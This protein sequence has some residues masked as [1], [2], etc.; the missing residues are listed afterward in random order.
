MELT[1][2]R[3]RKYGVEVV[4]VTQPTGDDPSQELMRQIIGIFDEYTSRENGKNVTRA[5]RESAKQGFWNGARAPLGYRVVEAERRGSK[6][7][8]KLAIDPVEVETVRLIYRLYTDGDGTSGPLGVKDTCSWLNSHG[9]R[10]RLGAAFGVGPVHKIL[11]NAG[12]ATGQWPYGIRNARTGTLNDPASIILIPVPPIVPLETFERVK[13]R[14]AVNNPKVTPP[15]VVN[16]PTLLAGLATCAACGSGMTRTGTRRRH[17][18]YTYYSCAGYQQKGQSVC[19]GLHIPM[20]KLDYAI[21]PNVKTQLLAPERLNVIL[22][23]LLTKRSEANQDIIERRKRL[24]TDLSEKKARLSRLHNAIEDGIVDL[25]TDLKERIQLLKNERDIIEATLERI[26][27]QSDKTSTLTRERIQAFADLMCDKLDNGDVQARKA[28]LRS[29]ITRIE[30][31]KEKV[32]IIG[33]KARLADIIA[34]KQAHAKN[35][36]GFVRKWR[37][38]HD[39]N[40]RPL[41][42]EGSALSS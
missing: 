17:K 3:L 14:L 16:G 11:T 36:R 39:S 23:A 8:K 32:R 38:R 29:V 27:S 28:Y 40:V 35:V 30:V 21:L 26:G 18:S 25:D 42:S 37:T 41:P 34:G 2:R 7:K 31:D 22:Q 1:I 20:Q 24:E 15:R 19:K 33:E 6:I 10:T 4:S 13:A 12:Y 5:M 9:Y